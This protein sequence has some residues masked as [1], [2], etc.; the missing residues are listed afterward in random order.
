LLSDGASLE[1][2]DRGPRYNNEPFLG[3]KF[4]VFTLIPAT[5]DK[6]VKIAVE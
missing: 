4:P 1:G 2:F 5:S 3:L 6:K